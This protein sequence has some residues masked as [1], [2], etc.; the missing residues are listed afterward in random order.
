MAT[1]HAHARRVLALAAGAALLAIGQPACATPSAAA[2][3]PVTW[4]SFNAPILGTTGTLTYAR[5]PSIAEIRCSD[6]AC[7]TGVL[8]TGAQ[9]GT[10]RYLSRKVALGGVF[11]A[12][13][14]FLAKVNASWWYAA[15]GKT[16]EDATVHLFLA[17][18]AAGT[19]FADVVARDAATSQ[20][21]MQPPTTNGDITSWQGSTTLEDATVYNVVYVNQ[22]D[23]LI[24]AACIFSP[25][26][27]AAGVCKPGNLGALA[28]QTLARPAPKALPH[29]STVNTLIPRTPAGLRPVIVT[30]DASDLIWNGYGPTA[31]M[32][33]QLAGTRTA[34]LQ[35]QISSAPRMLFTVKVA[36]VESA[37]TKEFADSVCDYPSAARI[38]C[39]KKGIA[40][41]PDG[42]TGTVS[43]QASA[44]AVPIITAQFTGRGKVG[45]GTCELASGDP[46]T[47][48]QQIVCRNAL[49]SL[50]RAISGS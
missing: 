39:V 12:E 28:V 37:A 30:S 2:P 47:V 43:A 40:G 45:V 15:G 5:M 22:G 36:P 16:N 10:S 32:T 33:K 23:A 18:F 44:K 9:V 29:G 41:V 48:Q 24:R 35:Y 8:P 42:Y 3:K 31:T 7:T 6:A 25:G 1:L 14:T 11:A 46:M 21:T 34:V 27:A 38:Q 19:V 49:G 13:P 50:A 17:Q 26:L 4:Q 20:L